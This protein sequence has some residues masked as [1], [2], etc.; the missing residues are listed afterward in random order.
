MC[1]QSLPDLIDDLQACARCARMQAA[2]DSAVT[3]PR[4]QSGRAWQ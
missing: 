1:T 4:R 2:G 3:L